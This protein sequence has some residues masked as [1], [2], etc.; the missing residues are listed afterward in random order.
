MKI[1][2]ATPLLLPRTPEGRK[3]LRDEMDYQR[4]IGNPDPGAAARIDWD[5]IA[6]GNA[7]AFAELASYGEGR[8]D[9]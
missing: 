6:I 5:D 2:H 8:A 1:S 4:R 3:A 9:G 7:E